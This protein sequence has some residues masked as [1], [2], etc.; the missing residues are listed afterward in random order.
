MFEIIINKM[1]EN[2]QLFKVL[3]LY[4]IQLQKSGVDADE[5]VTRRVIRL[6][7]LMSTI[8]I[9]GQKAGEIK[10]F[11]VKEINDILYSQMECAIFRLAVLGRKQLVGIRANVATIIEKIKA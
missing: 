8:I 10:P 11:T 7:H 4:L 6:Q 5:R 3:L 9:R 2:S 1:E